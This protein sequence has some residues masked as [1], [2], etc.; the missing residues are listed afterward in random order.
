MKITGDLLAEDI[1]LGNDFIL[2]SSESAFV[3]IS[4][5]RIDGNVKLS[6][7]VLERG[8]E[9]NSITVQGDLDIQHVGGSKTDAPL[10]E[11]P[12]KEPWEDSGGAALNLSGGIVHGSV[13]IKSLSMG[14]LVLNNM[15]ID[16]TFN[17][18]SS[19]INVA[20]FTSATIR[21]I[22]RLVDSSVD[23][24]VV[25][26]GQY[27]H[28]FIDELWTNHISLASTLVQGNM[29]FSDTTVS[30][31]VSFIASEFGGNMGFIDN[32][33][34]GDVYFGTSE[35]GGNMALQSVID[36]DLDFK[37]IN[38]DANLYL[39]GEYLQD[40]KLD[41]T[42]VGGS[43]LLTEGRFLGRVDLRGIEIGRELVLATPEQELPDWED[44]VE[45]SLR[46]AQ[47]GDLR[48]V[49]ASWQ[50]LGGRYGITGL[51]YERLIFEDGGIPGQEPVWVMDWLKD[52]KDRS[53]SF[54]PQPY[55]ELANALHRSGFTS[56]SNDVSVMA[57]NHE[58]ASQKTG[59]ARKI[60]LFLQKY[61][62]G[63][64]Y[65][66][67]RAFGWLALLIMI[68]M[69]VAGKTCWGRRVGCV[70]CLFFSLDMLLPQVAQ[71]DKRHD[72][73]KLGGSFV[74]CPKLP[75]GVGEQRKTV[76]PLTM[77][78]QYYFFLHKLVGSVLMLFA[79][80]GLSGLTK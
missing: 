37:A 47:V 54:N 44:G 17:M 13:N 63:Y 56:L 4:G 3:D 60:N 46:D 9:G 70:R 12:L 26:G 38:I 68:G 33:V 5:A 23:V 64:G 61:I 1:M 7:L 73:L 21:N 6:N 42:H 35:F 53:T 2:S 65:Q 52:Q 45:L 74:W 36:G 51:Q 62:I 32:Y 71:L 49:A 77:S 78:V 20:L 55:E 31:E 40:I 15:V 48:H 75:V 67:W 8:F 79:I 72:D 11:F 30:G 19:D 28:I 50:D 18:E 34:I 66:T 24:F 22:L 41:L 69:Y 10:F 58:L 43:V 76:G 16:R 39:S 80:A 25:M 29:V 14:G 27:N 59:L 57:R